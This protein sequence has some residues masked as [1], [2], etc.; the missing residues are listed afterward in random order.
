MKTTKIL[1]RS[2]D[3]IIYNKETNTYKIKVGQLVPI[4]PIL[5]EET[6]RKNIYTYDLDIILFIHTRSHISSKKNEISTV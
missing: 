3:N 5:I 6:D 4:F 1:T 2:I